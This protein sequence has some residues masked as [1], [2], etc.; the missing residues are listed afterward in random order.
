MSGPV[1]LT[2]G[3]DGN[4][5]TSGAALSNAVYKFTPTG[6]FLASYPSGP[7][8]SQATGVL[9]DSTGRLYVAE[10]VTNQIL[11]LNTTT[12]QFDLFASGGGLNVPDQHDLRSEQRPARRLLQHQQRHQVQRLFQACPWAPL[13]LRAWAVLT[14][15]HNMV[16]MPVPAPAGFVLL[17]A[18]ALPRRSRTTRWSAR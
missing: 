2:F 17:C 8:H 18:M 7:G 4:L 6:Q 5:L 14:G 13:S 11:R 15:T 10:S 12:N 16:Y 3:P 9:F 1:G